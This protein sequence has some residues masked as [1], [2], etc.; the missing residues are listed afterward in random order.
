MPKGSLLG[1]LHLAADS[2]LAPLAGEPGWDAVVARTKALD[3]PIGTSVPAFTLPEKDLLV[4]AV[5]HDS[6]TGSFFVSSVHRRKILRVAADGSATDFVAEGKEGLLS[7]MA[8]ALDPERRALYVSTEGRNLTRGL[9]AEEKG[10]PA[11]LEYDLDTGRRRRHLVP[12]VVGGSV[13]DLAVGPEGTL[14]VADPQTGRVYRGRPETTSLEVLAEAGPIASA[15]GLALSKGGQELYVADYGRGIARIRLDSGSVEFLDAPATLFLTGIDGLV[16]A[17]CR[18]LGSAS[19]V[20]GL[21]GP[22]LIPRAAR[23]GGAPRPSRSAPRG[24]R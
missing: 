19:C 22:G 13:G 14:Y 23:G 9:R 15:Q 2:D 3:T 18:Q 10:H 20:Q 21:T 1:S 24:A 8:L 4:E 16:L 7:A 5:V 17:E 6:K 12:P 11:V